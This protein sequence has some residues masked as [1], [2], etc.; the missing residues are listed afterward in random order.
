MQR[1]KGGTSRAGIGGLVPPAPAYPT[2]KFLDAFGQWSEPGATVVH[3]D[4]VA[5]I[6]AA[7]ANANYERHPT[8][9]TVIRLC[10]HTFLGSDPGVWTVDNGGALSSASR[11]GGVLTLTHGNSSTDINAANA[12]FYRQDVR[13]RDRMRWVWSVGA[14]L[15][16]AEEQ[17]GFAFKSSGGTLLAVLCSAYTAGSRSI[18]GGGPG[19]GWG[20]A[21]ALTSGQASARVWYMV[22]LENGIRWAAY[23][24]TTNQT[25]VPSSWTSI[26]T[27][28]G[29]SQL[30]NLLRCGP[31]LQTNGSGNGCVG[32]F[33]YV[34]MPENPGTWPVQQ[35]DAGLYPTAGDVV[36]L[37]A[38]ADFVH[39]ATP[40]ITSLRAMLADA[41]NNLPGDAATWT[42]GIV[43]S[44]SDSTP[45]APSTMASA[46]SVVL[47]Q[48]D[49]SLAAAGGYRY[50]AIYASAAS[51]GGTQPGSLDTT[52]IRIAA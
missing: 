41:I 42:F 30:D 29:S 45:N 16:T 34:A 25:A 51:S 17:A 19:G 39:A 21:P 35:I 9:P 22:T 8:L 26:G 52:L 20:S 47:R 13:V 1:H 6:V 46:A 4:P 36:P 44:N 11:S 15:D 18:Q 49:D 28:T 40:S 2:G 7:S 10:A 3:A 37:I 24:N 12:P 14:D 50:W 27:S 31:Y 43:G 33:Q 23:Y 38:S 32:R 48:P 5:T